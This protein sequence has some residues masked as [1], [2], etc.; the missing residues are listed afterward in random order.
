MP[1]NLGVLGEPSI[2]VISAGFLKFK[3]L[4]MFYQL[5]TIV[6]YKY[7]ANMLSH[8]ERFVNN[9]L[10]GNIIWYLVTIIAVHN[11]CM[12]IRPRHL[13]LFRCQYE[14]ISKHSSHFKYSHIVLRYVLLHYISS[15]LIIQTQYL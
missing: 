2:T 13:L 12:D 15:V 8:H 3:K 5:S 1:S 14:G 10:I 9:Y 11:M 7:T 4:N 6:V